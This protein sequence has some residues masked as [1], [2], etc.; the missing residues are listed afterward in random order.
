LPST[1][2]IAANN[3][4]HRPTHRFM[5]GLML[6]VTICWASNIIAGKEALRRFNPLALTQL[7]LLGAATLFGLGFLAS[8]RLQRL[9][10]SRRDWLYFLSMAATGIAL[11]QLTFIGGMAYTTVANTGLIVALGPVVVLGIAVSIGLEPLTSWKLAGM[12]LA[13]AGVGVLTIDR[14]GAGGP[15]NHWVGDVIMVASTSVFAVYTVLMKKVANAF[16]GLTLNTLNFVLGAAMTTPFCAR[17]VLRTDW[18]AVDLKAWCGLAFLVLFGSVFSYLLFAHV[19]TELAASRVAAFNYLQ[20]VIASGLGVW[21][22]AER[23]TSKVLVGGG[24]ILL[25]VYLAERERGE[26]GPI[27]F[28]S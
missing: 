17:A 26:P 1:A 2:N 4:S 20:P 11:N 22:L 25:G 10:L 14:S 28:S 7:R 24:L 18:A 12:L 3:P 6:L 13:F 23:L 19:L 8:G 16:D 5:H 27:Q 15:P 9:R 21:L